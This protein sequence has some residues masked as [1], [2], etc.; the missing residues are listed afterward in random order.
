V[1][2]NFFILRCTYIVSFFPFWRTSC[3]H[4]NYYVFLISWWMITTFA[5]F[6][7]QKYMP[8]LAAIFSHVIVDVSTIMAL[9]IRWY[10]KGK[11]YL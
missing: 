9:C 6:S 4:L 7:W 8:Q 5:S 11:L 3:F 10:P 1:Q 2:Y